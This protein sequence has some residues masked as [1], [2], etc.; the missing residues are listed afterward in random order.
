M[1]NK[2]IIKLILF[3]LVIIELN[4][5]NN[6]T[7]LNL[8]ENEK[9]WLDKNP[10]Q[11]VAV[12]NYWPQNDEGESLDTDLL[13]LIN[14][15]AGT[16]IIPIP[17]DVWKEGY[18]KAIN[19]D[20]IN[21]IMGLSHSKEREEFFY[22]SPAYDFNPAYLVVKNSNNTINELKDLSNKT[23]LL[24]SESIL[25]DT[26][27]LKVPTAKIQDSIELNN[28]YNILSL[29]EKVDALF[30]YYVDRNEL[31]KY[32]LKIAKTTY[33][34]N[35]EVS[36]G[37]NHKYPE[38][39]SIINKAFKLIP[40]EEFNNLYNKKYTT[41]KSTVVLTKKEKEW[42]DKKIPIKYVF[43]PDWA[44]LEW[45]NELNQHVGVTADIL[46]LLSKKTGLEF[47]AVPTNSW[48][49]CVE[50]VKSNKADMYSAVAYNEERAEYTKFSKNSI[51]Q[52][53]S[54]LISKITSKVDYENDNN[55]NGK[56]IGAI[57]DNSLTKKM[58]NLYPNNKFIDIE[59][60][61]D[62]FEKVRK[63]EIDLLLMDAATGNYYITHRKYSDTKVVKTIDLVFSLNIALQK[64]MPDEVLS[65]IDKGLAK[66]SKEE[67]D[68]IYYKWTTI[69]VIEQI[70]WIFIFKITGAIV[71]LLLFV[72]YH[73][74]RLQKMVE[75]KTAELSINLEIMDKNLIISQTDVNGIITSCNENMVKITGYRKEELIGKSHNILKHPD[76]KDEIYEDMWKT[77]K[78]AK[79]WHGEIKNKAKNGST[80]WVSSIISPKYDKQKTLIGYTSIRYDIT[81]KKLVSELH[82]EIENTQKEIIF[83]MGSIGESRS[84]ETGNHVKRVA[85]YTKIFAL[86]YGLS[87]KI[88][89]MLK[90]SSPMHDIGKVA[91]PDA[92]LNKPG[93]FNDEERKIMDTHAELGY[94]LLKNSNRELLQMASIIAHEHHEK[95]DGTGYPRK[96]KGEDIHIYGRIT[97]IADVFDALGSSRVY[98]PA[99]DDERIFKLFREESGKHFD[100]KLVDIFFNN[101]EEFL[102][103]RDSMTDDI[104]ILE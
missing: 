104:N 97:A 53:P 67:I 18:D 59:S 19:A 99:W 4:A 49:E 95:W 25:H 51:F 96:L 8:T 10:I 83:A 35:G 17:F 28:M 98:K 13:K 36:I 85:E 29:D 38:L 6:K 14:K 27:R 87:V 50:L 66:I 84:K 75:E 61:T 30:S 24:K 21:G 2:I 44:P 74:R 20:E 93:R 26:L 64:K 101:L 88:A 43:D 60:T 16:N 72:L 63:G 40:K 100:P 1:R 69:Q 15:Y 89:E 42:I 58:K 86:K 82:E 94:N 62:G 90:Q 57:P 46:R 39:S 76:M 92:I 11:K 33:D 3:F 68:N 79:A 52:F 71:L 23:V 47:Q 7:V 56:R 55:L 78:S 65:I 5:S 77:I 37:I 91:I 41:Y 31:L 12:M 70:D 103:I 48:K 80:Y 73:N 22:Y 54:V 34:E 45:K 81:H 32:N 9:D 102:R